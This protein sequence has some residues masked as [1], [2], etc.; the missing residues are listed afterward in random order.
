MLNQVEMVQRQNFF[1]LNQIKSSKIKTPVKKTR[2]KTMNPRIYD[3]D[4]C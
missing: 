1:S 4:K 3:N 2:S